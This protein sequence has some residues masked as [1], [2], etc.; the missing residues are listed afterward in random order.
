MPTPATLDPQREQRLYALLSYYQLE[1]DPFSD[2]GMSGLFFAGGDRKNT[3]EALLHFS[4]YGSAPMFLSAPSGFGKTTLLH[5][6]AQRV[7]QDIDVAVVGIEMLLTSA[8]LSEK[9]VHSFGLKSSANRNNLEILKEWL[10]EQCRRNRKA[11]L[12]VD[13]AQHLGSDLISQL[14]I[15]ASDTSL[16]FKIIFSGE[17]GSRMML[18]DA[19]EQ[20]NMLF[21]TLELIEFN[22]SQ[23]KDYVQYRMG[24]VGY[25]GECP[26]TSMQ[27][28]AAALRSRGSIAQLHD[29]VRDFLIAGIDGDPARQRKGFPVSNLVIAS[30]VAAVT[31][32]FGWR[33]LDVASPMASRPIAL[34]KAPSV[35]GAI[36]EQAAEGSDAAVASDQVRQAVVKGPLLAGIDA[37]SSSRAIDNSITEVSVSAAEAGTGTAVE[38]VPANIAIARESSGASVGIS[39]RGDGDSKAIGSPSTDIDAAMPDLEAKEAPVEASPDDDRS[40]FDGE[41]SKRLDVV[42]QVNLRLQAWSNEG[43][44]LQ[45]FGTHNEQRAKKLV[46]EYFGEADLLFYETR[47]NGKPWFVVING[48]YSGRQTA[49]ESIATLPESLRRLRPWPRNIASIKADISRYD[50]L[51]NTRR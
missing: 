34:E 33:S 18:E 5:E 15:L 51:L 25:R 31:I 9:I 35:E 24:A 22:Q 45:I 48:P 20:H 30:L 36:T 11:V 32:Y 28:Q 40:A 47:H 21:N 6:F 2:Q 4:R 38:S 29:M 19:V 27:L 7:E 44:A 13:D 10:F 17:P 26:L 12:C 23:V 42:R 46:E 3:V 39:V 50:E 49:Q 41:R 14:L 16:A 43:Y 1:R 8:H 37:D